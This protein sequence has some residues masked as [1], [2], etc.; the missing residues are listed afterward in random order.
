MLGL[1]QQGIEDT[2]FGRQLG[3]VVHA[4]LGLLTRHLHAG[5]DQILDDRVDFLADIAHFGELG[6]LD[7]GERRLG[8]L[9]QPARDLGLADA[10]RA[11]HE[12]VLGRDLA[13][14]GFIQLHAPPAVTQRDGDRALG[15]GL[16]HD[17]AVQLGDD[18][19]RGHLGT[20]QC[21]LRVVGAQ[22]FGGGVTHGRAPRR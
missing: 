22:L 17:M 12:N 13:A 10:G 19:A 21:G 5:F 16:A 2:L 20:G 3:V 18:L 11:D 8:Q 4:L 7:L 9:G 14:D 6:G 1:G 15:L